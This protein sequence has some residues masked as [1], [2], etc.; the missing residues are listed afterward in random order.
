MP[1]AIDEK[2][3][4]RL[5]V[6]HLPRII[7]DGEEH[8]RLADVLL[9]LVIPKRE[10]PEAEEQLVALISRL[11]E[12]YEERSV[13]MPAFTPLDRL[14]HLVQV[15]KLKQADLVD[16]FGSQPVVSQVLSGRRAISKAQARRL[17]QRF[18]VSAGAFI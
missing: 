7:L 16:V 9:H 17:A 13:E 15:H 10:L 12:D 11:I 2:K 18:K 3:Y 8:D 5:L 4:G 14:K 6:K 1:V